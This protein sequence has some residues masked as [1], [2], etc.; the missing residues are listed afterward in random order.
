MFKTL[1]PI[2]LLVCAVSVGLLS[3]S[4]Y[5]NAEKSSYDNKSSIMWKHSKSGDPALAWTNDGRYKLTTRNQSGSGRISIYDKQTEKSRLLVS[6]GMGPF[7]WREDNSVFAAVRTNPNGSREIQLFDTE[8]GTIVGNAKLPREV[9]AVREMRWIPNS[10][11][12]VFIADSDQGRDVYFTDAG[13]V[14]RISNTHDIMGI[15]ISSD[16]TELTWARSRTMMTNT[17]DSVFTLDMN[18]NIVDMTW[19]HGHKE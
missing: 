14:N 8:D 2:Q 1:K 5:A 3:V 10:D 19:N 17:P 7:A 4:F 6:K 12:V 11:N 9:H 13:I 18:K 15:R 16:G